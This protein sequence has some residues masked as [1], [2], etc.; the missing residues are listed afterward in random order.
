MCR[1]G[2][3]GSNPQYSVRDPSR[4]WLANAPR[5]VLWAINPRQLKSST[6]SAVTRLSWRMGIQQQR[7]DLNREAV[8]RLL[9]GLVGVDLPV[10]DHFVFGF[11][12]G[13]RRKEA[14]NE[15]HQANTGHDPA[16]H[17]QVYSI[18]PIGH[19]QGHDQPN[20]HENATKRDH[21]NLLLFTVVTNGSA[22]RLFTHPGGRETFFSS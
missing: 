13:V 6:M 5:S 20:N 10:L 19:S 2:A 8:A 4:R 15:H 14:S 17:H 1:L 7:G 11:S 12:R 3:V 16:R 22:F 9:A 21:G 18:D